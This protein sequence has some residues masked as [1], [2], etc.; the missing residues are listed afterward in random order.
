MH[1]HT[2]TLYS[3]TPFFWTK[4]SKPLKGLTEFGYKRFFVNFW[5]TSRL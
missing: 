2:H 1:T 5:T 3:K 4:L